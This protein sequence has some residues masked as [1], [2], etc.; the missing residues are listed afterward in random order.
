MTNECCLKSDSGN[1]SKKVYTILLVLMPILNQ[2]MFGPLTYIEFFSLAS[3]L[4]IWFSRDQIRLSNNNYWFVYYAL[5]ACIITY[6][7]SIFIDSTTA[8]NINLRMVKFLLTTLNFFF[9]APLLFDFKYGFKIYSYVILVVCAILYFQY[10]FH[11]LFHR[12]V[13]FLIPGLPLNYENGLNSSHLI[14]TVLGGVER[15]YFFRPTSVF[16]EPAFYSMYCLPWL[17]I[18]IYKKRTQLL[19]IVVTLS[20]FL[21]TSTIGFVVPTVLWFYYFALNI[22]FSRNKLRMGFVLLVA[23]FLVVN[24][25]DVSDA[26]T[27]L[28]V[29]QNELNSLTQTNSLTL[30]VLRGWE[31]FKQLDYLHIFWGC[32]YGNVSAYFFENGIR[33]IYD[34]T[35]SKLDYMS[36]GFLM[37]CSLGIIGSVLNCCAIFALIKKF[38]VKLIP[39]LSVLFLLMSCAAVWNTDK[40]Y[41]CLVLLFT[42]SGSVTNGCADLEKNR[43]L[44]TLL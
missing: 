1:V 29:K 42:F 14:E 37:L 9:I 43:P 34:Y 2:Y 3:P 7:N 22:D 5:Y 32:G 31:C 8:V 13:N 16:I 33:T 36:G 30:R 25:I 44:N 15:G 23:S 40:Y 10:G 19:A 27:S 21:S 39:L 11:I 6:L 38:S 17:A 12:Q 20:A 28:L 18:A 41:L 35:N 24:Y 26:L 4:F